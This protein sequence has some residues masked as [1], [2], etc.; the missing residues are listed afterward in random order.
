MFTEYPNS[1]RF[2]FPDEE[3]QALLSRECHTIVLAILL[4]DISMIL[5]TMYNLFEYC[6]TLRVTLPSSSA[7]D[8]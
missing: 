8:P 4:K 5:I 1:F 6:G 7:T 2:A 3:F